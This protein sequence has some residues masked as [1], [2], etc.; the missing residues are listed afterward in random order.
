MFST[1]TVISATEIKAIQD[2]SLAILR[3]VGVRV[4][5]KQILEIMAQAGA[6][7]DYQHE[8]VHLGERLVLES[9]AKATKQHIWYGRDGSRQARFGYGDAVICSTAGQ[10]AWIEKPGGPRREPTSQDV[11]DAIRVGDALENVDIVGAMAVPTDVPL[12]IRDIYLTGE[13]V[14]G[15]TKPG[16]CWVTDGTTLTYIL[17]IYEAVSGGREAHRQMPRIQGFIEPISPLGFARPGLE[18]LLL[19]AQ[20]G[21][22]V[23]FGPMAQSGATAP[24]TLAGTLAQENAEVLAGITIAQVIQPGCPV[25]FGGI[26]HVM[27]MREM[28]ISFGS[29]EQGIMATAMIQIAKDYGF[30]VYVNVGCGDSKLPDIQTGLERGMLMLMGALAGGDLLGH[31]GICGADQ[32]ASLAQLVIDNAMVSYVKRILRGF[33]VSDETLAVDLIKQIGIGG[34]YLAEEHTVKHFRKEIWIPKGFDRRNW[35]AWQ[36]D[37]AHSMADWAVAQVEHIRTHHS[38]PLLDAHLSQE[39]DRIMAA[40]QRQLLKPT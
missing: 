32:G 27:D 22:P 10:Y 3:D 4:P 33:T 6:D 35:D 26:P 37:G 19:C 23:S 34:N 8:T 28:L 7:V 24:V 1:L 31:M 15:T 18:I 29:P 14:K 20:R 40:G 39:I 21:L 12:P 5:H 16:H 11:S 13:I 17:E 38:P 9:I 2:A 36:A 25:C 30:P